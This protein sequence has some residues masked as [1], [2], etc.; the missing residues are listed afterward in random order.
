MSVDIPL[1]KTMCATCPFK[2]GS[3]YANL[4]D[5]LATRSIVESRECHSTGNNAINEKTG[6]PP[7]ICRGSRDLQLEFMCA[8]GQIAEPT[9][10]AW[11]EARVL[12]GMKPTVIQ[13]PKKKPE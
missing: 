10:E 13:D 7:H 12:I 5:T 6:L 2:P 11:N 8:L 1:R 9:D 4:V 3:K